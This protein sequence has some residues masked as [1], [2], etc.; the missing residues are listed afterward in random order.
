MNKSRRIAIIDASILLL[1]LN[2]GYANIFPISTSNRN[3]ADEKT[4]AEFLISRHFDKLIIKIGKKDI[5]LFDFLESLSKSIA[6]I[7]LEL[8]GGGFELGG[9]GELVYT[10]IRL[11]DLR[12]VIHTKPLLL[13]GKEVDVVMSALIQ[14]KG[15]ANEGKGR[16]LGEG[17]EYVRGQGAVPKQPVK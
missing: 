5:S 4:G 9:V 15:K 16:W 7:R 14:R 2:G 10:S 11:P 6:P 8:T 12:V 17:S 1:L 13:N 3:D